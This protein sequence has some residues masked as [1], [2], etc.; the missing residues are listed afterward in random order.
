VASPT[1][2]FGSI[3]RIVP[4]AERVVATSDEIFDAVGEVPYGRKDL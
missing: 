4:I 1:V 3:L 2:S